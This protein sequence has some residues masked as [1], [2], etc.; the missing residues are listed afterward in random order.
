MSF[1]HVIKEVA[2]GINEIRKGIK[3][4]LSFIEKE[5]IQY[6]LVEYKDRLPHL[7]TIIWRPIANLTG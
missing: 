3:T 5:P 2:S 7:D 4:L 1:S 6:L